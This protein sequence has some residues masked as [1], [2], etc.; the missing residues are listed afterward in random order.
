MTVLELINKLK[1]FDG[2]L[3]VVI[4]GSSGRDFDDVETVEPINIHYCYDSFPRKYGG[5]HK[6]AKSKDYCTPS[7]LIDFEE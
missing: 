5:P 1:E 4:S 7:V 3:S 6:K 2:D